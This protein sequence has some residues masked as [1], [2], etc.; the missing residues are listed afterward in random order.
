[1]FVDGCFWHGC[2]EHRRAHRTN[3]WYWGD[4]IERNK[5]RD[6][7]TRTRL[8]T[9]GWLACRVW[10]HEDMVSAAAQIAQAVRSRRGTN[11]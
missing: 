8:T 3:E 11:G 10:E 9:A 2:P 7:D 6:A 4:K 5:A 1:M